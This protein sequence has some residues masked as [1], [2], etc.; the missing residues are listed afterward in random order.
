MKEIELFTDGSCLG[1]QGAGGYG[2]I[3]RTMLSSGKIYK[4]ELSGGER[5]TTNN[6]M[7]LLAVIAGLEALKEPCK[8][9]VYSDSQYIINAFKKNWIYTWIK[10]GWK[11][12]NGTPVLNSDLWE[13]LTEAKKNHLIEWNW[14][15]GHSGHK[16]NERCD[17]LAKN[18][19][20]KLR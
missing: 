11:K 20:S 4:K 1:N 8:V 9:S 2:V 17:Y 19:A 7:E 15:K 5:D 16:E 6:R 13:R 10:K 18:S 14:V 12:S 3:L